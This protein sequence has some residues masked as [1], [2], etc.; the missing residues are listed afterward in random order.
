MIELIV[1]LGLLAGV[2]ALLIAG[3]SEAVE[4]ARRAQCASNLRQL[5]AANML[6]ASE[7]GAYVPAASDIMPPGQNNR[8]W[9]GARASWNEP[10]DGTQGPLVP[11]LGKDGSIRRCPSFRGYKTGAAYN[12]FE[13]SCGGYGYNDRG[14][15]SRVYRLGFTAE[16]MRQGMPPGSIR[17]PRHTVMFADTALAQPYGKPDYLI[18]YAFAEAYHFVNGNPP[19]ETAWVATP[20]IHFRHRKRAN[21][22]WCD[23]HVSAERMTIAGSGAMEDL[24][25]GW[26][27]PNDNSLFDPY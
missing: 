19:Q 24:L 20:S 8:R 27:G 14:V 18:E 16:A 9:H 15:G 1:T 3:M 6:Y 12:A 25:I 17:D 26:F 4:H 13:S 11:F 2:A 23:G 10:F 5:F 7:H 21:V 22:V